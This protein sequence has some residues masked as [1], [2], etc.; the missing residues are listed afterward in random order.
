MQREQNWGGERRTERRMGGALG[1]RWRDRGRESQEGRRGEGRRREGEREIVRERERERE[2]ER[3]REAET[4][5][6][7]RKEL[8]SWVSGAGFQCVFSTAPEPARGGL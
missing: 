5:T 3:E 8:K 1:G 6:S 7:L 4:E 2:G